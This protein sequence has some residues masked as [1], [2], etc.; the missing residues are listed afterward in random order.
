[1][2]ASERIE[3]SLH[4]S[5]QPPRII[6][7]KA[8]SRPQVAEQHVPV[9]AAERE[10]ERATLESRSRDFL[11]FPPI[12]EGNTSTNMPAGYSGQM[13]STVHTPSKD[14]LGSRKGEIVVRLRGQK[15]SED[16]TSMTP[17]ANEIHS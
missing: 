17:Q 10:A 13:S 12:F 1:M 6:Q 15:E 9:S 3:A 2:R 16:P 7:S 5:M 14:T 11:I 4:V 8:D